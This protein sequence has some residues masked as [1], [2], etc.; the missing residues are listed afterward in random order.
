MRKGI[1][2][3]SICILASILIFETSKYTARKSYKEDTTIDEVQESAEIPEAQNDY[4]QNDIDTVQDLDSTPDKQTD[5]EGKDKS[6]AGNSDFSEK[7]GTDNLQG[8]TGLEPVGENLTDSGNN[9]EKAASES[10]KAAENGSDADS[11]NSPDTENKNASDT[12][13]KNAL[14]V[15]NSNASTAENKNTSNTEDSTEKTSEEKKVLVF[16]DVYKQTYQTEINPHVEKH[17]Y[18]LSCFKSDGNFTTY[19]GDDRYSY[20]MGIDV[21]HHNGDID[22]QQVK[23]AGIDFVFLR[24]GYRGY[25]AEGILNEDRK[26]RTFIEGAHA[27]GLDVGC[28]IYSQAINTD[29]AKEEADLV[30]G[31]LKDYKLELPVVYDPESVLNANARTDYVT[32]EQFTENTRV[33]CDLIKDAGYQPMIYSNMLWEAFEFDL[34]KLADIPV[35]Y[36]DYEL[37]PQT[38]YNFSFW[39][40]S[41]TGLVPGVPERVDLDI[42]LIKK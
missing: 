17:D 22:W 3:I 31:I 19:E 11:K 30:L 35:W 4:T 28:Y 9:T 1:L 13:S 41:N 6:A 38:P 39:Q 32:G 36:A 24:I 33:F 10:A 15:D 12:D 8:K 26:F 23:N 21:S 42:Q 14:D 5:D 34:E 25:G 7:S 16:V 29:E 18:D 27:A 40:Y 2:I 37:L 20:R